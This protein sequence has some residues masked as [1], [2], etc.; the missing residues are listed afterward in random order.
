MRLRWIQIMAAI[1]VSALVLVGC[2]M[3]NTS[4]KTSKDKQKFNIV[5]S[6]YPMYIATINVTKGVEGVEVK[7]MTKPQ[8]G[9][10]HDYQLTPEDLKTLE[11]ANAF[12]VNGAGMEAFLDK[13][14]KQQADLKIV[15]ASKGITLLKEGDEENPHVWVSV[16][17]AIQQVNQIA[18]QLAAIDQVHA[19][20]YKQNA[21]EYVKKLEA[22]KTQMHKQID[23]LPNKNIVTFHEAFPYF[24]KE[25]NLNIVSVIEREPGTEPSPKE[26]EETIAKIKELNIKALFAE[27][28]YPAGAAETISKETGA[29]VY[30]L[31]PVVT[32]EATPDS[33]D[34]YIQTMKKNAEV[35]ETALK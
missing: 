29:K 20:Q 25:F 28:Q 17:D 31:D 7:N 14:V 12:V 5:T 16:S 13:V 23:S 11:N 9:C 26:L 6:F 30:T 24:A 22:L 2:G 3:N 10:L 27:P 21:A 1:M 34:A 18:D 32:G 15:D 8:T 19:A 4:E 33:Y 35:L